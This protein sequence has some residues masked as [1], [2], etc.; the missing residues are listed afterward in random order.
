EATAVPTPRAAS[1]RFAPPAQWNVL[2]RPLD[3]ESVAAAFRR[4]LQSIAFLAGGEGPPSGATLTPLTLPLVFSGFDP[5]TFEWARGVFS[6]LGFAPVRGSAR[7][8]RSVAQPL[9]AVAP[10][11]AGRSPL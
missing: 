8:E 3:R 6:C 4:P 7:S 1:T 9:P 5:L 11:G 2:A 10:G